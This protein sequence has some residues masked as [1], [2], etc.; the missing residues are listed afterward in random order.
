MSVS[1]QT[2]TCHQVIAP[3]QAIHAAA[4]SGATLASRGRLAATITPPPK[5]KH[6]PSE[7]R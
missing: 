3:S 1:R 7:G 5:S 4:T 2:C 6:S